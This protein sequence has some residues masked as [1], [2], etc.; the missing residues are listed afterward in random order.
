MPSRNVLKQYVPD[1]YYHVHNRGVAK[2]AIFHDDE[3]YKV[4][5]NLFKRYLDTEPT[6][7]KKGREY[8]HLRDKIELLAYCL[9]PNHFHLLIYINETN[10]TGVTTLLRAVTGAYTV[11]YNKKYNRVGSLFQGCFKASHILRDNY[12]LH[13]SRYIHMNPK[14]YTKWPYSSLADYQGTRSTAWLNAGRIMGLFEG[15]EAK[16]KE[17]LVDYEGNKQALEEIRSELASS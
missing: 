2:Q 11:Y 14:N 17:F 6:K 4:F 15:N 1:A 3:D 10:S 7:D 8:E 5:L 16:Y 12:L 13:I 9:M